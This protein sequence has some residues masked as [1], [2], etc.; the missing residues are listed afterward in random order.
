MAPIVGQQTTL[1]KS[2]VSATGPRVDLLEARAAAGECDVVA[3]AGVFAGWLYQ[4]ATKNWKA[5]ITGVPAIPDALL[6][7]FALIDDDFAVTFT[8]VP[9]GN[10]VRVALDRDMDGKL[11]GD[12]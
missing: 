2:N 1:R 4:P 6:R 3:R 7:A 11:D 10:G 5:N 12:F 9:P 8:A